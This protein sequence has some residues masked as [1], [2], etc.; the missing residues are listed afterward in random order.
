MR[1]APLSATALVLALASAPALAARRPVT[2]TFDQPAQPLAGALLALSERTGAVVLAPAPLM[3]GRQAPALRGTMSLPAA[4]GTLLAG[5]RLTFVIGAD[6]VVTIAPAP[7]N[8]RPASKARPSSSPTPRRTDEI[9]AEVDPVK[10]TAAA[11]AAQPALLKRRTPSPIDILTEDEIARSGALSLGDALRELPGAAAI[12]DGGETRQIAI[13]GVASRFTRVRINGMETL[14]TFGGANAGGGTNRGRAFD[15]NVFAADLFRQI[16][17]QKTATADIDEG[18]LGATIDI[19]T[20]SPFDLRDKSVLLYGEQTW[21]SRADRLAPRG[22]IVL[23][24]RLADDRWGVLVSAAWSRRYAV[25]AGSTAGGWQ[26]G[27]ALYPGFGATT[28]GADL[29]KINAALHARIPRLELMTAEQSRLGLTAALEWRPADGTRVALDLLYATLKSRRNEYLLESFTFRTAG[30]CGPDASPACGLNGVTAI[31]PVLRAGGGPDVLIA[32]TFDG[33]DVKS[34]ARYDE[35]DTIFRQATLSATRRLPGDI[36][37]TALL[38]FSRSDFSNPVQ[39]TLHLNQY[40]VNGF[41]YDFRDRA[42]PF[43]GYGD[44]VLDR[45]SA[46]TLSEFRD[47]PNWVDN[48]Y[49]T[50]GLD[51]K[52]DTG[53]V[54]W[55]AGVLHKDYRTEAVTLSRSNGT[56]ANLNNVLPSALAAI[57]VA[58]YA[59]MVG[60]GA[61]FGAVDPPAG[62]LTPDVPRGLGLLRQACALTSCGAFRLGPEPVAA[63]NY[64]ISERDDAAYVLVSRPRRTGRRLWGDAGLRLAR[65][66]QNATGSQV[67]ADG[68]LRPVRARRSYSD[69]LPSANLVWEPADDLTVRL[70][71]ARVMVRPDLRSLRPGFTISTTSLK[72]VSAGDPTLTPTR[73]TNLDLAVEWFAPNGGAITVAA[74]HKSIQSV[75]QMTITQPAPFSANPY[76]LPDSAASLACGGAAGCDPALPIWQFVR[77]AN[78]GKGRLSGLEISAVTPLGA[79]GSPLGPWRLQGSVAYTRSEIRYRM[80][81]GDIEAIEDA[82]GGPRLVGNLALVYDGR[83]LDARAAVSHSDSY[84]ASVP[85]QSGGDAEGVGGRTTADISVRYRLLPGL[86]LTADAINLTDSVQ[87]QFIDRSEIPNYQHRTGREFRLGLRYRY[88]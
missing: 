26:T 49:K 84:L 72:T 41:A 47:D 10:V 79:P 75:V 69:V 11:L 39:N 82:L 58:D 1:P 87:R 59:R 12:S 52:G 24:R 56:I 71:A 19:S 9:P 65:T 34:E 48:S 62:W 53:G 77:P 18:S 73:A 44:A 38:G 83:R 27:D 70:G 54:E 42:H 61:S 67:Q 2:F 35:L 57:P 3:A 17:L 45:S 86:T 6:G 25:D 13:R 50:A 81:S 43:V 32:G 16:R 55:R 68:A 40:G 74:Y 63:T 76:G 85:A 8:L 5:A 33:V 20:R 30:A 23:S 15:Y 14:A 28:G 66:A 7:S 4:L 60:A 21:N 29:A 46:W 64:A 37:A 51:L 31:N 88:L 36:E 22:S 78:T 80:P